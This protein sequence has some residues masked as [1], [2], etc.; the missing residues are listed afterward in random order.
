MKEG[1]R[2]L[3]GKGAGGGGVS[4]PLKGGKRKDAA[5]GGGGGREGRGTGVR[6]G[7]MNVKSIG[8]DGGEGKEDKG[9]VCG[10]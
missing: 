10:E 5:S 6:E 7:K 9:E 4:E 8:G 1:A 3:V 2:P